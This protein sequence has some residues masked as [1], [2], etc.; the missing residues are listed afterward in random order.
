MGNK[1][2]DLFADDAAEGCQLPGG[3]S[4][5]C[6]H[7]RKLARDSAMRSATILMH[8]MVHDPPQSSLLGLGTLLPLNSQQV[9]WQWLLNTLWCLWLLV[10]S[11]AYDVYG[12][13]L[14]SSCKQTCVNRFPS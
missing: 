2:A 14:Q 9:L 11:S 8:I 3:Y 5:A 12:K 7:Y 13:A 10:K 6:R 1:L 4:A